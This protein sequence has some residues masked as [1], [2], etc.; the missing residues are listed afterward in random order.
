MTNRT[1]YLRRVAVSTHAKSVAMMPVAWERMKSIRVG[2]D[3]PVGLDEL[4]SVDLALEHDEL[5]T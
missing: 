1:W 3:R 2:E 4:C 5:V